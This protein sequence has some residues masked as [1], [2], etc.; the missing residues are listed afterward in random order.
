MANFPNKKIFFRL[1]I[2][3]IRF[4]FAQINHYGTDF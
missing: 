3:I 4:I 2:K 1:D